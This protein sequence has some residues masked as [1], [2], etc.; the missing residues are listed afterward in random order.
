MNELVSLLR[1]RVKSAPGGKPQ[2]QIVGAAAAAPVRR[3]D[4]VERDSRI[5][6]MRALARAYRGFGMDLI[7][8]QA[9]VGRRWMEDMT[10]DELIELHR[11]MDRARECLSDGVTFEEAGLLRSHGEV[12]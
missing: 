11:N 9:M 12:A 5:R 10:D 6:W 1:Q 3:M 4:A 8:K 7:V 2:L